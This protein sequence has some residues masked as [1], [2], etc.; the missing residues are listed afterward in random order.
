MDAVQGILAD[1]QLPSLL[2]HTIDA[3]ARLT[4]AGAGV[5]ETT[6][7]DGAVARYPASGHDCPPPAAAGELRVV[8]PVDDRVFAT[9]RLTARADGLP[10]TAEDEALVVGIAAVAGSAIERLT[11][12]RDQRREQWEALRDEITAALLA[13]SRTDDVLTLAAQGIRAL[14]DADS[15]AVCLTKPSALRLGVRGPGTDGALGATR[16]LGAL[17][18]LD[19][20]SLVQILAGTASTVDSAGDAPLEAMVPGFDGPALFG[21][22]LLDDRRIGGLVVGRRRG[23]PPFTEID[24]ALVEGIASHV[25]LILDYGISHL[26]STR[27]AI[28]ADQQRIARDLHDT[29]IQ[30]LFAIGMSLQTASRT[31]AEPALFARVVRAVDDLDVTISDIRTTVHE[32]QHPP[33]EADELRAEIRQLV[34]AMSRTYGLDHRLTFNGHLD[35]VVPDSVAVHVVATIREA[36]SNVGRHA[37]ATTVEVDLEVGAVVVVR[38][39]DDGVG[40]HEHAGHRSGLRNLEDRAVSLGGSM[41]LGPAA[42]GGTGLLW[43]VPL[44]SGHSRR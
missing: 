21:P 42:Q 9:I 28:A 14:V 11:L 4:G 31:I 17:R 30:Q 41:S 27:V 26:E 20:A 38:V 32:L 5:C 24:R 33:Q 22:L 15:A 36:L 7:P 35:V 6:T 2:R 19:E 13:G 34:E 8:V 1:D 3:A 29:V 44:V 37:R 25:S 16:G 39:A 18:D 43:R 12:R 40:V 23:R 10:F